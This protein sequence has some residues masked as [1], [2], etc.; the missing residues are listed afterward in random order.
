MIDKEIGRFS[1]ENKNYVVTKRA[2]Y[3]ENNGPNDYMIEIYQIRDND[4]W[5]PVFVC[6]IITGK[7]YVEL[8]TAAI[9]AE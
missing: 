2:I 5:Y 8:I 1:T 7:A 9:K 6:D 3:L 4:E